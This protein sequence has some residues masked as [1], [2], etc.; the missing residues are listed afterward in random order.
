MPFVTG[1]ILALTYVQALELRPRSCEDRC[2]AFIATISTGN[3]RA[4]QRLVPSMFRF[5]VS[6]ALLAMAGSAVA[7]DYTYAM[8]AND[9]VYASSGAGINESAGSSAGSSGG[10]IDN[11]NSRY[12]VSGDDAA[13]VAPARGDDLDAVDPVAPTTPGGSSGGERRATHR[14]QSLVP[15]AIK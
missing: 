8:A 6:V 3:F 2:P 9:A 5:A 10:R 11:M 13:G 12:L 14:W 1:A 4:M 7:G 15:G